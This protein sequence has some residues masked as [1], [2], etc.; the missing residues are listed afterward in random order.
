[1]KPIKNKMIRSHLE[2]EKEILDIKTGRIKNGR[3]KRFLSTTRITLAIKRHPLFQN[4]KNDIKE[5]D[6]K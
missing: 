4:I 1:M 2:F 3:D 5:A 6:L